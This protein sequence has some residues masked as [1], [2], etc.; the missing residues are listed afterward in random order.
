MK[1]LL[2]QGVLASLQAADTQN[3]LQ[4]L[5][6]SQLLF[7]EPIEGSK[8]HAESLYYAIKTNKQDIA[9]FLLN[10]PVASDVAFFKFC[11]QTPLSLAIEENHIDL[12]PILLTKTDKNFALHM[13]VKLN[14]AKTKTLL[15]TRCAFKARLLQFLG[16]QAA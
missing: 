11:G 1:H 14:L 5:R 10:L 3:G 6:E 16:V 4:L 15:L 12:L 7:L 8:L 13:A 9:R 2:S